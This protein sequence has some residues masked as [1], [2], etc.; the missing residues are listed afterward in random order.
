MTMGK[1]IAVW[2]ERLGAVVLALFV[3]AVTVPDLGTMRRLAN[4]RHVWRGGDP[5]ALVAAVV[6]L[7]ALVAA[8]IVGQKRSLALRIAGWTLL[9]A[10][11]VLR[12]RL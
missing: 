1:S 10:I 2:A 11:V 8:V 7:S 4:G 3:L 5:L 9:M 12:L 6:T